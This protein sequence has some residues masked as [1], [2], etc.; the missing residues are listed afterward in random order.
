MPLA[1]QPSNMIGL[2]IA[3]AAGHTRQRAEVTAES[4][5]DEG[6]AK[7]ALAAEQRRDPAAET[8]REAARDP[9]RD[10]A[11]AHDADLGTQLLQRGGSHGA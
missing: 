1:I 10:L 4:R 11:P 7:S 6:R 8:R 2:S 3:R 9:L 5:R